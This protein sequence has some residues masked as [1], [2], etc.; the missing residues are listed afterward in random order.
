MKKPV[1][2]ILLFVMIALQ[3]FSQKVRTL[4]GSITSN[5]TLFN[6]TTYILDGYVFVKN[7]ATLSIQPGTLIQGK[8]GTKATL[9]VTRNGRIE[10]NGTA[11]MPIVMTSDQS[12]GNRTK[13]DWGGLV[14]LG[15]A[16]INRPTDCSSCAGAAVA[17]NEAGIQNAIEGDLD[18]A[19][20]DGLY[21]GTDNSHSSGTLRYVRVEFAGTVITPGNEING[22]TFGGV[23]NGTKIEYVQVSFADDDAF[24]WFGGTV[25]AK[26]LVSYRNVDDDFDTDFGFT[27]KVQFGIALRD[28]SLYDIGSGP[29][30]NGFE[31]DNDASGTESQPYT[32]PTFSNMTILGPL[33]NGTALSYSNSFQNGARIRRNSS[34]SIYNSIFMG[35]NDGVFIDGARSGNKFINDTLSFKNNLLAGNLRAVN[36]SSAPA[37]GSVRNKIMNQNDSLLSSAGVLADPFNYTN[38]NFS[39]LS[40]SASTGAS[41]ADARVADPFFT[42]TTFRGAVGTDNWTACWCNFN[43][44]TTTYSSPIN[45]MP[46]TFNAGKDS[47]ICAGKTVTLGQTLSGP[48][49]FSWAPAT[50]LSNANAARPVASPTANTTY[51]VTVTDSIT[52]CSLRDTVVINVT[53]NPTVDFTS[54]LGSNGQVSFTNASSNASSYSW[55]FGDG[56]T[57]TSQNPNNTYAANGVYAVTLTAFNGSCSAS[58]KKSINVSGVASPVRAFT[59]DITSNTTFY[60]DSIYIINGYTFVKNNAT[61]TIQPGTII[62]GG[63]N[64]AT[65]IITR[66]GR[67]DAQGS[68]NSPIVFTSAKPA[69]QRAKG[70]WG[71]VIILG[72]A[73]INRPTDCSTC[74]GAAVAANEDGI[75][76]AIEGDLDNASGDALYGGTDNNHSSGTF[77][78]VRI[79]F[80]GTVITPGNEINGLT[81]GGL[82]KGTKLDH[83]QVSFADDDAF[84]WF[85]GNVDAKNLISYRNVDDDF[86]VDFGFSGKVQFGIALRDSSLYDIGSGP[87]TNGFE[88]DND[89]SGTEAKPFTDPTFSN[90]TILG[91]LANGTPLSYSN[92]FQN[93]AR[94]RRNS[95]TSIYNSVFMGWN[96]AVFI[97]GARSGNKL[98]ND[99]LFFKNNVLAGNLRAV[100]NSSAPASQARG[101]I[102]ADNDSIFSSAG[103]LVNPFNYNQ[104]DFRALAASVVSGANYIGTKIS[105]PFFAQVPFKG[106]VGPH[107]DSNWTNCWSNYDPQNSDYNSSPIVNPAAEANFTFATSMNNTKVSFTNSSS[108]SKHVLWNFG[109]SATDTTS[110]PNPEFTFPGNGTYAVTLIA[111][112]PCGNNMITKNVTVNDTTLNPVPSFTWTRKAGTLEVSFTNTTVSK[113]QTLSYTWNFGDGDSSDATNPVHTYKANGVYTVKLTAK[114]TEGLTYSTEQEIN[115]TTV[116]NREMNKQL[117]AV[118]VYPNPATNNVTVSFELNTTENLSISI[119]DATGKELMSENRNQVNAG[120]YEID[121]STESLSQG[122]YIIRLQSG[123]STSNSRLMIV[124]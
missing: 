101:K 4:S 56:N 40:T 65:L 92:S 9:I 118:K 20:G 82:G 91:P 38:P 15:K 36:N 54:S 114:N 75:Q 119:L 44:N 31:S 94:L 79:E 41:F 78:Y 21:G 73:V 93:G 117:N 34:N 60:K 30:T 10:A 111:F 35:W 63:A 95:S 29:T 55:N 22:I 6:D 83:I 70:D 98:M 47:S 99:T 18:N 48:Y 103:V 52:G 33:A 72:K 11:S 74:P 64:K 71:G 58:V 69:G 49:K 12:A 68:K 105:D 46:V 124:K 121:L 90:M 27:G 81:M 67:I 122:I 86:D 42:Q 116:G 96:D 113:G 17:A 50:G 14:I 7:N 123:N 109:T 88:S 19:N 39:A 66:N 3:G 77:S 61:L 51:V 89:G 23:G 28:S 110:N 85:G 84:E 24:E 107:A 104:P 120:S 59:G 62:K 112:S 43:P 16:I 100:N 57:S 87:T 76:A 37:G 26:H 115:V 13:G 8:K 102:M 2:L 106:A 5:T 1:L 45:L 25:D 32:N 80:A 97:D 108:F 53:P